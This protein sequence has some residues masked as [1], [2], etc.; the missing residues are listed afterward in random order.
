MTRFN[1][2]PI[3]NL[4]PLVCFNFLSDLCWNLYSSGSGSS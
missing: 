1:L 4:L 3:L 2:L